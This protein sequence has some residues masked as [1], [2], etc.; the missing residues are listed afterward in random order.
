L[1]NKEDGN[2]QYSLGLLLA[3]EKKYEEAVI[4][5]NSATKLLPDNP[6]VHYNLGLLQDYLGDYAAAEQSLI[7]ANDLEP[8]N[9]SFQVALI[10]FY[11]KRK[12]FNKARPLAIDYKNNNPD[13][14]SVNQLIDF[15]DDQLNPN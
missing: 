11:L 15:I 14:P 12:Q 9:L 6:R 3:E 7:I 4:H 5:L 1:N 8:D 2:T 10:D 13:D